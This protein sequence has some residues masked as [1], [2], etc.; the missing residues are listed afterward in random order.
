MSDLLPALVFALVIGAQVLAVFAVH[1]LEQGRSASRGCRAHRRALSR[2]FARSTWPT[3]FRG[4]N[5]VAAD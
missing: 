3:G 4:T 5:P 1:G 2:A